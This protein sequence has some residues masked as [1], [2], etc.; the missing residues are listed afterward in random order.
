MKDAV[1]TRVH[2]AL[3]DQRGQALPW[4]ATMMV[5]LLGFAGLSIDVGHVFYCYRELQAATDAAALAGAEDL[6]NSTATT[7]ATTYSAMAGKLN[8]VAEH[9]DGFDG[10]RIPKRGVPDSLEE[11]GNG[12]CRSRQRQRHAGQADGRDTHVL[13][14][15]LR[16]P[17]VQCYRLFNGCYERL[18]FRPLQRG[19]R[20][21]FDCVDGQ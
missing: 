1:K 9:G 10:F 16:H 7:T 12:L 15:P 17:N 18:G 2:Q 4:V 8:A 3:R 6:P 5:M 21:R 11:C 14:G 19:D 20:S 13:P